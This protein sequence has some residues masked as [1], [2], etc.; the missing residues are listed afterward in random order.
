MRLLLLIAAIMFSAAPV[1][2]QH[3][4]VAP[5]GN[6]ARYKVREQMAGVD[7]PNDAVG[8]TPAVSGEIFI[9]AN[10]QVDASKSRIVV[11]L[12]PLKSDKDRRDRYIQGRT[13]ETEKFPSATLTVKALRGLATPVP[14]SGALNF[15][16]VGDLEIHGVSKETLWN[17][18]GRAENGVYTGMATT[19][20]TFADFG[21]TKPRVAIVLSVDEEIVLEYQF[22][23]VTKT[24]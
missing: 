20:F 13:L 6:E 18:I 21:M 23:L 14:T 17:V 10:G 1:S 5:E 15:T 16:L 12:R 19:R 2:A 3:L 8:A 9:G 7:F 24:P 22:R 11:D 4:V